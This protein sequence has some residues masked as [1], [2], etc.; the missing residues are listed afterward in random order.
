MHPYLLKL[1]VHPAVQDFFAPYCR[2]DAA[3]NLLFDYS[4][5]HETYGLA[6]HRVPFAEGLWIAGN[7]NISAVNRIFISASAM[8]A[9]AWLH[10]H[11][12]MTRNADQLCFVATGSSLAGSKLFRLR[13]MTCGKQCSL[14]FGND[15]LGKV[16]DLR[17]AAALRA[18]PVAI[19]VD[20][21]TIGVRFRATSYKIP[22][23]QFS[24]NKFEKLASFR[25]GV[26]TLKPKGALTW[27][28]GLTA[29]F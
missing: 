16:C 23:D 10:Y 26:Q 24:I 6:W 12:A 1:G 7:E 2:S 18:Q 28:D 19:S 14:L 5:A 3:G 27:L 13:E 29:R 22:A 17:V 4:A 25:F 9:V 15:L 8:E 20:N 21:D 11:H